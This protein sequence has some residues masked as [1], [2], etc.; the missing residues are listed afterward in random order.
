MSMGG[1]Q[2]S[3]KKRKALGKIKMLA[4]KQEKLWQQKKVCNKIEIKR[5]I[6]AAK[7]NNLQKKKKRSQPKKIKNSDPHGEIRLL[8]I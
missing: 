1:P 3:W 2:E 5:N 6:L 4:A 8:K 7:E